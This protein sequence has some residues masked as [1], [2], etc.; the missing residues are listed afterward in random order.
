MA[1]DKVLLRT[2][3]Y[4][5]C[6]EH[7]EQENTCPSHKELPPKEGGGEGRESEDELVC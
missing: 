6:Q 5:R 3:K 2:Q 1:L 7:Q 4:E